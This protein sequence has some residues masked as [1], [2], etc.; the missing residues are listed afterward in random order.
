MTPPI[1]RRTFLRRAAAIG[2]GVSLYIYS[3]GSYRMVNA[4]AGPEAYRL[5]IIH[6]NDHHARVEPVGVTIQAT[7]S[8]SRNF[9][10]VA[11]RKTIFDAIRAEVAAA[12]ATDKDVLFLD[13][14]DVFQGTLW[15]N[16]YGGLADAEFYRALG[17]DAVTI[18]NHEF[19]R[20]TTVLASYLDA[21]QSGTYPATPVVPGTKLPG[22]NIPVISANISAPTTPITGKIPVNTVKTLPSGEKIGIFGM[23]T[24]TTVTSSS[25]GPGVSFGENTIEAIVATA[26]AQVAALKAAPNSCTKIILLSHLGYDVDLQVAAQVADLDVIVGGHTHTPLLVTGDTRPLGVA[27]AGA[28]PTAVTGPNTNICLVVQAWEWGK[29]VGDITIG[30]DAAGVVSGASSGKFNNIRPVWADGLGTTPRALLPGEAA[31]IGADP[32]F[33]ARITALGGPGSEIDRI[34][35]TKVG[36][37]RVA[38]DGARI[39]VRNRATN[40]GS[41]VAASYLAKGKQFG[42]T[43][44]LTNGGGIRASIPVGDV[45]LGQVVEVAPF[46]TNVL[47]IVTVTGAQLRA[48]LENGVSAIDVANPANS[49]G[50]FPHVA[51]IRFT[52]DATAPVGSRVGTVEV[53]TGNNSLLYSP[54]DP[55]GSYRLATIDFLVNGGD[56]YGTSL[57]AGTDKLNTFFVYSDVIAEYI[58]TNSPIGE[59]RLRFPVVLTSA[60]SSPVTVR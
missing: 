9:G 26:N 59:R 44:A 23:T 4:A 36:V 29:W 33:Q 6:T 8:V 2:A 7:P 21:M 52:F 19:D 51:G 24:P 58:T 27:S 16:T 11:R 54:L 15:F 18:G 46:D 60:L 49:G 41:L 48:A 5:R 17:Y 40:L 14:G 25:P 30:F 28:Y 57:G 32:T 31:D 37:T 50:R 10:G 43:C 45:T 12:P 3:D 1:S 53:A 22:V 47:F 39:N 13:A 55:A 42:A 34:K 38:L 20:G 35:Q 56:G